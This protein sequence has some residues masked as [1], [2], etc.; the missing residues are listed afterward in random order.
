MGTRVYLND[1]IRGV[2]TVSVQEDAVAL[3]PDDLS[4]GISQ[5]SLNLS[6]LPGDLLMSSAR[7]RVEDDSAGSFTGD[8]SDL[9][10]NESQLSLTVN[11]LMEQLNTERRAQPILASLS[12]AFTTY[13]SLVNADLANTILW[14]CSFNPTNIGFPGWE[15]NVW[16][17][18]KRLATA[19]GVDIS[20]RD[21]ALVFEDMNSRMLRISNVSDV[22]EQVSRQQ[23]AKQVEVFWYNNTWRTNYEYFPGSQEASVIQVNAGETITTTVQV[24]GTPA[25]LNQPVCVSFVPPGIVTSGNGV[26]AVAGNDGV[27][28]SPARWGSGGGRVQ[29]S[30]GSAPNTIDIK[31]TGMQDKNLAPYS[32]AV[33]GADGSGTYLMNSLHITGSGVFT[34][35]NSLKMFTGAA[36]VTTGESVGAVVQNPFIASKGQA[37]SRGQYAAAEYNIQHSLDIGTVLQPVAAQGSTTQLLYGNITGRRFRWG[38]SAFRISSAGISSSEASLTAQSSVSLHNI[39]EVWRPGATIADVNAARHG[40]LRDINVTPL[41]MKD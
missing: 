34:Q 6:S 27:A 1:R 19:Y 17:Q 13:V 41:R 31:V 20:W 32:L 38:D 7:V 18:I 11:S 26:Y 3:N 29:V 5:V 28:I 16:E 39:A 10:L 8:V 2:M 33:I 12:E 15:G 30:R 40:K 36:I 24:D 14:E 37:V 35:E 9:V 4:G 22:T 25:S 23:R 21:S